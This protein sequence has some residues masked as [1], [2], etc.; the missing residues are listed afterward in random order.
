M[1]LN[2][3]LTS[4]SY[5]VAGGFKVIRASFDSISGNLTSSD[6][7]VL[8]LSNPPMLIMDLTLISATSISLLI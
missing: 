4:F 6:A 1:T 3:S 8:S 2:Q 5:I 7:S